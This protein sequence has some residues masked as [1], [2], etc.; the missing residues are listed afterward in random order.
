MGFALEKHRQAHRTTAT[1]L[2]LCLGEAKVCSCCLLAEP[3]CLGSDAT[4]WVAEWMHSVCTYVYTW[5]N[6]RMVDGLKQK[7]I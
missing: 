2:G 4:A 6:G 1:Y 5:M 3:E 7:L